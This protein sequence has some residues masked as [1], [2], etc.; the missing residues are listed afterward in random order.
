MSIMSIIGFSY[1]VSAT[2]FILG[3]KLLGSPA[4]ARKGNALSAIGML[5]A[6]V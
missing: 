2:L 3:L 5:I 4:T 1:V 6:V